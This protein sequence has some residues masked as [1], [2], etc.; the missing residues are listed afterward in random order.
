MDPVLDLVPVPARVLV[1]QRHLYLI[2]GL[3]PAKKNA[4]QGAK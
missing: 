3:D 2:A 1:F 4:N